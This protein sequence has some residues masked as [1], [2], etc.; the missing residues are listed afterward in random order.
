MGSERRQ[1]RC[2]P[3]FIINNLSSRQS[4][5]YTLTM[6]LFPINYIQFPHET[7]LLI[8]LYSRCVTFYKVKSKSKLLYWALYNK[9]VNQL[10]FNKVQHLTIIWEMNIYFTSALVKRHTPTAEHM[11]RPRAC[12]HW[13][14][15]TPWQL[16]WFVGQR[17]RYKQHW[18]RPCLA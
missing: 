2:F 1:I 10:F 7:T 14:R 12:H 6:G 17:S 11:T 13:A 4:P 5:T 16:A 15:E 18:Q 3:T 9:H 8:R